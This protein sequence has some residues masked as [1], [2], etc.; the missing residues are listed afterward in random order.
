MSESIWSLSNY[1]KIKYNK[2]V[3][4]LFSKFCLLGLTRSSILIMSVLLRNCQSGTIVVSCDKLGY[5]QFSIM[6][7][8]TIVV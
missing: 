8:S 5:P 7:D 4:M 2:N 3:L 6:P 1:D